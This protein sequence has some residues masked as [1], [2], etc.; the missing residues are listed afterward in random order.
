MR[1]VFCAKNHTSLESAARLSYISLRCPQRQHK[2]NNGTHRKKRRQP[3]VNDTL[4]IQ[5]LGSMMATLDFAP[6][7]DLTV[8]Q[9][10]SQVYKCRSVP[11]TRSVCMLRHFFLSW[12]PFGLQTKRF[13]RFASCEVAME[14]ATISSG[15]CIFYLGLVW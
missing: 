6:S 13:Q 2:T 9:L 1:L 14:V 4:S 15:N 10:V 5:A 11:Y 8:Q 3:L 7:S 12:D